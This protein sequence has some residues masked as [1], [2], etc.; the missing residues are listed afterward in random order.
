MNPKLN[1]SN[2]VN[3]H[4]TLRLHWEVYNPY[5]WMKF[6]VSP[7][8]LEIFSWNFDSVGKIS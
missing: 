1:E 7:G 4:L 5:P 8:R 3:F 6:L 2:K